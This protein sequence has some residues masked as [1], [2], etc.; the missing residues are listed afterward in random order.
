MS[1]FRAQSFYT[2][3]SEWRIRQW[4][5]RGISDFGQYDEEDSKIVD[6]YANRIMGKWPEG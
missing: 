5:S 1:W 6:E 4:L 2:V 3:E